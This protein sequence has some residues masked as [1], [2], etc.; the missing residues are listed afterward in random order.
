MNKK[1]KESKFTLSK[2][3][4]HSSDHQDNEPTDPR[5]LQSHLTTRHTGKKLSFH[6]LSL[7]TADLWANACCWNQAETHT[8][9]SFNWKQFQH[10]IFYRVFF[11]LLLL[12]VQF[13]ACRGRECNFDFPPAVSCDL[14]KNCVKL[15][16]ASM[17]LHAVLTL[18]LR[19]Y[20]CMHLHLPISQFCNLSVRILS[21]TVPYTYKSIEVKR[22]YTYLFQC[23]HIYTS[24]YIHKLTHTHIYI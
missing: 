7:H 15:F 14:H 22:T 4:I 20:L 19:L 17:L 18:L 12:P 3:H 2:S 21:I 6:L 23:L 16:L 10:R 8:S 11:F 13:S 24:I 9:L 1:K 5:C